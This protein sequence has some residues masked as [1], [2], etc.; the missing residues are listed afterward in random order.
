MKDKKKKII[1]IIGIISV[2][3]LVSGITYSWFK[4]RSSNNATVS[5]TIDN[6]TGL[7]I[8]FDGGQNITGILEPTLTK[9]EGIV[10]NF[11]ANT[12]GL[13]VPIKR[14]YLIGFLRNLGIHH[15]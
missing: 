13:N 8:T 5:I 2:I 3:L 7:V 4:W 10:K 12:N 15:F 6:S 9:E 11:S 14:C 1:L